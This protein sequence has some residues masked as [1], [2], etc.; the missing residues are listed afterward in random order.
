MELILG[1]RKAALVMRNWRSEFRIEKYE[2]I[3]ILFVF[4]KGGKSLKNQRKDNGADFRAAEGGV[5]YEKLAKRI[6]NREV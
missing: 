1:P 5:G 6:S 2:K 4:R 3:K